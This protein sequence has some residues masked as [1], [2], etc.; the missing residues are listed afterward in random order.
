VSVQQESGAN[1]E[2]ETGILDHQSVQGEINN[3]P[4]EGNKECSSTSGVVDIVKAQDPE[5][6]CDCEN[7]LVTADKKSTKRPRR[8]P[9]TRNK[10]I[11]WT[12]ISKN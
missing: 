11:L 5:Q 7:I 8:Q 6:M 4:E 9:V 1:S 12:N 2:E 10:D 3:N